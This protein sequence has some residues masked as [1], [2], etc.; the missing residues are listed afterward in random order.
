MWNRGSVVG[1]A[2][3]YVVSILAYLAMG[4]LFICEYFYYIEVQVVDKLLLDQVSEKT[5]VDVYLDIE[6]PALS[7]EEVHVAYMAQTK[8]ADATA[9]TDKL[10]KI[11]GGEGKSCRIKG[12][13]AVDKASGVFHVSSKNP[14]ESIENRQESMKKMLAYNASHIIHALSFDERLPG[15]D[16]P[17]DNTVGVKTDDIY[18]YQYHVKIVPTAFV[19]LNGSRL[20]SNQYSSTYYYRAAVDKNDPLA[21]FG[22]ISS[23]QLPGMFIQFEFSAISIEKYETKRSFINFF[24]NIAA[25]VG[26][27]FA[28]AGLFDT[29]IHRAVI[30]KKID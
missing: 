22:I 19:G 4:Y 29:I 30:A 2:L 14:M 25:I 21:R 24:T 13:L 28:A 6:F 7:C 20:E 17:L 1:L 8:D 27:V 23:V 10:E 18:Q 3:C 15:V 9:M 12:T 16:Y 5:M 11:A 26:G